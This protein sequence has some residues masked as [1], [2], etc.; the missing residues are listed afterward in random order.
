MARHLEVDSL[1]GSSYRFRTGAT[2][3]VVLSISDP[4]RTALKG[5]DRDV[6]LRADDETRTTFD[7]PLSLLQECIQH[8]IL[9]EC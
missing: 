5:V 6:R 8:G 4:Y 2:R 3:L 7:L 1:L 9:E